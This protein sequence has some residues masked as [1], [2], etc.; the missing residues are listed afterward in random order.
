MEAQTC[1]EIIELYKA[2]EFIEA[3]KLQAIVAQ[4]DWISIQ[5]GVVG[6]KSGLLSY[7]G[8]GV[9]GRKPLPSMTKQEAFK[10]SE[11]FKELVAV[12]KAL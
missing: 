9:C 8:Y 1:V 11:D 12:E 5:E 4:G 7:F 3:Q 10:Y 6:T 2:E